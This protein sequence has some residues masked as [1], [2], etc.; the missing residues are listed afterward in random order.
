MDE[1]MSC[2]PLVAQSALAHGATDLNLDVLQLGARAKT[3]VRT[4]LPVLCNGYSWSLLGL[5]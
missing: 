3:V 4:G 5:G 1:L 2:S